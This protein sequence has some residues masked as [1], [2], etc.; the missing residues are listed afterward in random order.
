MQIFTPRELDE[1]YQDLHL[2]V[3]LSGETVLDEA[4]QDL[5]LSVEL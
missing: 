3:E 1:A 4:H 5:H 2:C